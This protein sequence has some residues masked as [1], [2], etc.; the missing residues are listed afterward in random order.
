MNAGYQLRL[1]DVLIDRAQALSNLV[2]NQ[3]VVL[4]WERGLILRKARGV[5][6]LSRTFLDK[7]QGLIL[8]EE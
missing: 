4:A 1:K 5:L 6:G 3:S 2:F 7:P 8:K